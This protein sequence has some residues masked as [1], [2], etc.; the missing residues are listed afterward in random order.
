M[1]QLQNSMDIVG[2]SGRYPH[3]GFLA[4]HTPRYVPTIPKRRLILPYCNESGEGGEVYSILGEK[5]DGAP[6]L[7]TYSKSS[8]YTLVPSS[9]TVL[10]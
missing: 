4:P 8:L 5:G 10:S 3:I 7:S 1:G 6:F 9:S 2:E